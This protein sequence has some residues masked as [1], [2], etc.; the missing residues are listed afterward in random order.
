L[1]A[2]SKGPTGQK[3]KKL[4]AMK[5]NKNTGNAGTLEDLVFE[6][7]NKAYGAYDLNKKRY[8]FLFAAFL[9]TLFIC[10]SAFTWPL[11]R[12][13]KSEAVAAPGYK[14]NYMPVSAE[15]VPVYIP[16]PPPAAV[17]DEVD[18]YLPPVI[19]EQAKD[20]NALMT[21]GELVQ[22][23]SNL[24]V[25]SLISNITPI[26]SGT[27]IVEDPDAGES[28]IIAEE[29]ARFMDGDQNTFHS[30]VMANVHYPAKAMEY[31]IGG[32]VFVTFCINKAGKVVDINILRG[33]DQS[34]NDEVRRVLESSPDWYPARQAGQK[35]KQLFSMAFLF[36]LQKK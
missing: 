1:K 2:G 34:I 31:E 4:K 29:P 13:E 20:E 18:P 5:K 14:P 8:R 3:N 32:R 22:S 19:V 28:F 30:W 10:T 26:S 35:V 11:I 7:R 36:E 15:Q 25:D 23:T 12:G 6:H 16:P 9:I 17:K 33:P 21:A 27:D 24:P